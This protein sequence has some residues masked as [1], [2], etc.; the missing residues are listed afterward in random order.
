NMMKNHT[1]AKAISEASW[2]E[3]RCMLEYKA[4]W[5]GR[6]IVVAPSHYASSQLCSHCGHKHSDVKNLGLRHW[7]CP[8]CQTHHDRDINAAINLQK[9]IA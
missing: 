7:T 4:N 5:Y 1:L 2:Y 6:E 9:L 8:K 3:F